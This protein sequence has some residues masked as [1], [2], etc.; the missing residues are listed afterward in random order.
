MKT[1]LL[2]YTLATSYPL[3]WTAVFLPFILRSPILVLPLIL[4][5]SH[6]CWKWTCAVHCMLMW[7]QP[8]LYELIILPIL[9]VFNYYIYAAVHFLAAV[10][11][12]RIRRR[13][14][15]FINSTS[16]VKRVAECQR[17][18]RLAKFSDDEIMP[19][20]RPFQQPQGCIHRVACFKPNIVLKKYLACS[21]SF[22]AAP[23]CHGYFWAAAVRCVCIETQE[24]VIS[25]KAFSQWSVLSSPGTLWSVVIKSLVLSVCMCVCGCCHN[26]AMALLSSLPLTPPS[27]I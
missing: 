19:T 25:F 17:F 8:V 22:T 4:W 5:V 26:S 6:V 27:M 12:E 18:W 20:F 11:C 15:A 16:Y 1:Q 2:I 21:F 13:V 14:I 9:H 23:G 7:A 3:V 24:S 10:L